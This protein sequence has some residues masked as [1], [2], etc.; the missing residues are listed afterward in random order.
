MLEIPADDGV[1]LCPQAHWDGL[2][3]RV[4]FNKTNGLRTDFDLDV[5]SLKEDGLEKVSPTTAGEKRGV[6]VFQ[7]TRQSDAN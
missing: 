1:S 4:L 5:I 6:G 2:T 3:G 7:S